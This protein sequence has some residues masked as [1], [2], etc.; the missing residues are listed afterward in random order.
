MDV[1]SCILALWAAVSPKSVR[2]A[3]EDKGVNWRVTIAIFSPYCCLIVHLFADDKISLT[4]EHVGLDV[5]LDKPGS[6]K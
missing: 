4:R 3:S 2:S 1:M 5:T 6:M